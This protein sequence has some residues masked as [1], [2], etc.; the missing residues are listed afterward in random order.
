MAKSATA[1]RPELTPA[2][3]TIQS[4]DRALDIMEFI[5]REGGEVSLTQI[6]AALGLNN[7][8]CH[9]IIKTLVNRNYVRLGTARGLYML[10]SQIVLLADA[11]N[12]KA[13]LPGRARPV[14]DALNQVTEEAVHLAV[15]HGDEMITLVKR[16]ALHALRVDSGS[17]GKSTAL[18]ATATGKAL[19]AGL[20]DDEV[21]RVTTLHGMRRF[22]AKTC[23]DIDK[24]L[25]ELKDVRASGF[26]R[27]DEEFQLYVVCLGAPIYDVGG[28]VMASLS[29]S[30]PIN[31]ATKEHLEKIRAE[32]I[33]AAE[34][35]SLSGQADELRGESAK[36][37]TTKAGIAALKRRN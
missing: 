8:T 6:S 32:T 33:K 29:V 21:R 31:R 3:K 23:T 5:A 11:V 37:K 2:P 7:S 16:E 15:L 1:T 24:L 18:H 26:S 4:V 12:I 35:L 28:E 19:L 17:I 30:T 36:T 34:Q 25:N 10:G 27:D 14:L 22:T 20:D 9:H 13:E